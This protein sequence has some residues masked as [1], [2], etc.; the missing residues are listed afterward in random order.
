MTALD[1][2][3]ALLNIN[4]RKGSEAEARALGNESE[5]TNDKGIRLND[6]SCRSKLLMQRDEAGTRTRTHSVR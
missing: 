3:L 6:G 4:S 5:G 1:E 2:S